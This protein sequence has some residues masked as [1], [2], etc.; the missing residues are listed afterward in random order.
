MTTLFTLG[1][2]CSHTETTSDTMDVSLHSV[3]IHFC[4]IL[5]FY[6]N[7]K[8]PRTTKTNQ[9]TNKTPPP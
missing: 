4:H 8:Y 5:A 7:E 9:P 1:K 2:I 6:D 3:K